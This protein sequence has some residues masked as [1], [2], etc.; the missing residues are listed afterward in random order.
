[1]LS[2]ERRVVSA[3]ITTSDAGIRDQV[4]AFAGASLGAMPEFLRLGITAITVGLTGWTRLAALAGRRR[5]DEQLLAWL[6]GH[7]IGLVRQW[8]R[9]LRSL[10]LFSEQELLESAAA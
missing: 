10:V 5:T 9:A 3:M 7:P 6:E 1:M 4:V 2:F 8:A